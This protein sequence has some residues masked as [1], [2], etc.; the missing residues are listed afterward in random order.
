[1][2]DFNALASIQKMEDDE[3]IL[4][5]AHLDK[6]GVISTIEEPASTYDTAIKHWNDE[7]SDYLQLRGCKHLLA[8][9]VP[10]NGDPTVYA[11][12]EPEITLENVKKYVKKIYK[13]K[14]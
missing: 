1:M 11:L 6:Y 8:I 10:V 14:N 9:G 4:L 13:L 12:Y 7:C 5:I 2:T 3:L